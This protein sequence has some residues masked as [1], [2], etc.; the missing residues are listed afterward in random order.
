MHRGFGEVDAGI[1]LQLGIHGQQNGEIPIG[2]NGE[3]VDGDGRHPGGLEAVLGR[4][5]DVAFLGRGP[6]LRDLERQCGGGFYAIAAQIVRQDADPD[7]CR[8]RTADVPDLAVLGGDIAL[9]GLDA[10]ASAYVTPRRATSSSPAKARSFSIPFY[11]GVIRPPSLSCSVD[12][13]RGK[14]VE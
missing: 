4:Q 8:F 12:A 3:R 2:G 9:A 14:R 6:G 11:R 13:V 1:A 5:C 7:A 10:R